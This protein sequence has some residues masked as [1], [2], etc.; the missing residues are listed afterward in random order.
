MIG[1]YVHHVGHGHAHRA[2]AVSRV[3]GMPVTGL[4]SLPRPQ[5]WS[6]PW[7]HLPRD[8][9]TATDPTAGG[10]LHWVPRH[11]A[12]L[13]SRMAA[14]SAWIEEYAPAA[15][16]ADVS[17]EIALLAR[18]HGVPVV[19]VVLPGD[20]S[21]P[22]HVLGYRV[23]DALV[24]TW[25]PAAR[26]VVTGLPAEVAARIEYVGGLSRFDPMPGRVRLDGPPRVTLLAGTGGTTLRAAQVDAARREATGWVWTVLAP[27]P[28]GEW[29]SDPSEVL[30]DADVVITHAGQ[31]A[32]AEV[33]AARRP[34]V[35]LPEDRPHAEQ[36]ATARELGRPCWP[37]LVLP[38]WPRSGW[39]D[40]LARAA[41]QDGRAWRAWC[42]GGAARRFA[43]VVERVSEGRRGTQVAG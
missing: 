11:D 36:A 27:P 43:R 16:V 9:G 21:D 24:A 14:V 41:A 7:V 22:A 5:D 28:L 33:A 39:P 23:S 10:S 8:D 37:A 13:R 3:L 26:R 40:L 25:P 20:R 17:V 12:G 19:S 1:W 30:R 31:N 15:I 42:D 38:S 29:S 6:G 35:V 2:A 32:V 4:S 34:A 18:L